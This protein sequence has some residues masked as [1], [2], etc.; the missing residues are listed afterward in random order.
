MISLRK[1]PSRKKPQKG[2]QCFSEYPC[3]R[4]RTMKPK[5]EYHVQSDPKKTR[6]V[7]AYCK[8][9][10]TQQ[11]HQ[12]RRQYRDSVLWAEKERR[13]GCVDC[14]S[15]DHPYLMDFDHRPG[16]VKCFEISESG[17]R[18]KAKLQEELT[19]CDLVCVRCHRIRTWNRQNPT[20]LISPTE[21][22]V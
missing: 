17:S 8:S 5:T 21:R 16:E 2:E 20:E 9:C 4:C 6:P 1:K 12:R 14:G 3:S 10:R 13:G 15:S 18:K 11:D 22:L 7:Y 19:K